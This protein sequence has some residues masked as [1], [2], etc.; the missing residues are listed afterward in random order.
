MRSRSAG[1]VEALRAGATEL[2][3]EGGGVARAPDPVHHEPRLVQVEHD[4]VAPA[5][6][7]AHARHRRRVSSWFHFPW[8]R[9]VKPLAR[10]PL[11]ALPHVEHR[12][13]GRVHEDRAAPAE[14]LEVAGRHA[15]RRQQHHVARPR[16]RERLEARVAEEA[17][18][19]APQAR[20]HAGVVDD[21]PGEDH[22]LVREALEGL[23]R[24]VDGA[25]H[26]VAEPE[27]LR[28]AER[29]VAHPQHEPVLAEPPHDPGV[30]VAPD[31]VLH[32]GPHAEALRKYR[33]SRGGGAAAAGSAGGA[34]GR[35]SLTDAT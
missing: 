25:V 14:L 15:E 9:E 17:D 21:L 13:A 35:G 34:G 3:E 11:D 10:V 28:E 4:Q 16:A 6:V 22:A 12:P 24:V 31:E 29:H 18:A 1:R 19:L 2:R 7:E 27:L 26:A 8:T 5:R 32:L 33:S 30:V 20:V 23:V